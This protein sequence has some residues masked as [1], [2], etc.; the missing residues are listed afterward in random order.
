MKGP[1]T[2][3]TWNI[4][5]K[6]PKMLLMTWAVLKALLLFQALR[7]IA[8]RAWGWF[9]CWQKESAEIER[10]ERHSNL[11][12]EQWKRAFENRRARHADWIA[13]MSPERREKYKKIRALIE[14]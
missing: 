5:P 3:V 12:H 11:R 8:K 9:V 7:W 4:T 10:I 6:R 14:D 1:V 13:A 2:E